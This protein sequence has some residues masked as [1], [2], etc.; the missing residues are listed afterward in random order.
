MRARTE[1]ALLSTLK[2]EAQCD[3]TLIKNLATKEELLSPE[4]LCTNGKTET[5]RQRHRTET[6]TSTGTDTTCTTIP[7]P[8]KT[9]PHKFHTI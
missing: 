7:S 8:L 3:K 6:E 2:R 4:S 9:P 1:P 5:K